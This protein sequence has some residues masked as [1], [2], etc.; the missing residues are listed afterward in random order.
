MKYERTL[1]SRRVSSFF[2]SVQLSQ[3]YVATG[4]TIALSLVVSSLT[5]VC[6]DFTHFLQ[7]C[8]DRLPHDIKK[9]SNLTANVSYY[10]TNIITRSPRNLTKGCVAILSPLQVVANVFIRPWPHLICFMGHKQT[11]WHDHY[12]H[13]LLISKVYGHK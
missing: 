12:C 11:Y 1:Q 3:P 9:V 8:P 10:Y 13:Y 5:S 6:C 4:H 2:L 7:W